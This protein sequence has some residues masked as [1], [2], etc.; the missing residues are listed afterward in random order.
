MPAARLLPRL[1][2]PGSPGP[3]ISSPAGRHAYVVSLL[4][5]LL[6]SLATGWA[7]ISTG[8]ALGALL[9]GTVWS[10]LV[11]QALTAAALA[12]GLR[13]GAE[14]VTR[15]SATTEEAH[16]RQLV[17]GHLLRLGPARTAE[18]RSGATVSLLTDGAQRVARYRQT[19]LAPAAASLLAPLLVLTELA[20]AVD[21]IVS[22][23]LA[24]MV[25]LTPAVIALA[26]SRL[27]TSSSGSRDARLRLA[28]D[29][30]D[31]IQGLTT[32]TLSRAARRTSQRLAAT[33]EANRRSLMQLLAGNQLV[34]LVTDGLFS[35][36]LVTT[37][38]ALAL[39][40]LASGALGTGDALAV[41]LTSYAL[42]EPLDHV[43]AFFYVGLTGRANQR[44]LRAILS[45]PAG[46]LRRAVPADPATCTREPAA[47]GTGDEPTAA[48]EAND[49]PEAEILLRG[50]EAVWDTEPVLHD[51]DLVVSAGEHVAVVG[52]SGA[53]KSTLL[54]VLAGDLLPSAGTV[55][56]HGTRLEASTQEQVRQA[57]ARVA[58]TTWLLTGT[59]ADN[60]QLARPDATP[61]QMW[62]ALEEV[63]LAEEVARMPSG[64]ATQVG[65]GGLGLSGG[66]AQRVSLARAVLA[67]RPVLLLDEPTS[68]VDLASEAAIMAAVE[69]MA[70]GR[71]VVT[72]THREGAVAGADR[73]LVVTGGRPQQAQE[74]TR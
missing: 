25:V 22:L 10:H 41:V 6:A 48:R 51:A 17:L 62:R 65:E 42:L 63:G 43:G 32:L 19:F 35:L 38:T 13:A 66:Q 50:V 53:G 68:H 30:L 34:I 72:V 21:T 70:P 39:S 20:L 56:V 46:G 67:D 27:R 73:V 3:P 16:L 40:R 45:R 59:I 57:S 69:T 54:A 24:A 11:S 15:S 9:D 47:R 71:A 64:L 12:G 8:W 44:S 23:V 4:L 1:P 74:E 31:A 37:A 49:D 2:R 36:L 55:V 7:L 33:G 5:S 58:Q 26:H 18:D 60:L 28:A 14:H 61:S 29:Y 52:P